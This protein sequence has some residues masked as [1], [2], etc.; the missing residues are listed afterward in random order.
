MRKRTFNDLFCLAFILVACLNALSAGPVSIRGK[1]VAS[2][3]PLEGAYVGAH[4]AGKAFT[5]W[6]MTD[7]RSQFTFRGLAPGT[8]SV[9]TRIPGFRASEKDGVTVP[10]TAAAAV[11][12]FQVQPET[13]F[14]E[15]V[16][17]ASNADLLESFPLSKAQKEALDHRCTDCHGEYYIAKSKF[18]ARDWALI[19]AK[20][21]DAMGI[22][23]AGDVAPPPPFTTFSRR[24]AGS[25]NGAIS[26]DSIVSILAQI[27]GPNSPDFPIK[28]QPRAVGKQT[29]ATVTEFQIPRM[30]ATPR[31]VAVDPRGGYVWYTDWRANFLG[32]I[33]TRTGEIKEFPIPAREGRPP[34]FQYMKWDPLGNLIAGQIWSGTVIRF[35]VK[36]EKLTAQWT[37]PQEW[38]RVGG[39]EICSVRGDGSATYQVGDGLIGTRWILDSATGQFTELKRSSNPE[40]RNSGNGDGR[41]DYT[42]TDNHWRAGWSPGGGTRSIYFKDPE[43]GRTTEF[44]IRVNPWA[45]PY[46][47]VGDN[48]RKVGWTVPDAID[49]IVKVD[50]NTGQVTTFPLP[51]HGKEVRNIDIE[52]SA[53]PPALWFVNQ[54]LGRIIRF[55]EDSE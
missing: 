8:Y 7:A 33:D 48:V 45:R 1:V 55:Q 5:T 46:N 49:E 31:A 28:F 37:A 14:L 53:N 30:G 22:T 43:T 23:P 9:F 36:S 2:T 24:D 47:A 26:D 39:V 12:D 13:D 4:A 51:S 19:V 27:R 6:V 18:S 16:E 34:G 17:Q 54:R 32:R 10:A 41:C 29:R 3:G 52:T 25:G 38:A 20:M 50:A 11:V 35:D 42:K 44:P 21:N 15:L 40:S